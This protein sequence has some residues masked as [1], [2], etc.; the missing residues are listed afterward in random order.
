MSLWICTECKGVTNNQF[1]CP[2]CDAPLEFFDVT[3]SNILTEIDRLENNTPSLWMHYK[4]LKYHTVLFFNQ[5]IDLASEN[6]RGI[7]HFVRV[8]SEDYE[9]DLSHFSEL[10]ISYLKKTGNLPN[11]SI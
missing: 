6:F 9:Q 3:V 2:E 8:L 7:Q 5:P 1:G 4:D 10:I 11:I